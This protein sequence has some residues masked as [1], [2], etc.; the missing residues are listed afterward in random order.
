MDSV[1]MDDGFRYT[2]PILRA[3]L[4]DLMSRAGWDLALEGGG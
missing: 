3:K 4:K 2:L 1:G